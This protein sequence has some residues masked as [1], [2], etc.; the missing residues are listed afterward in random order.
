M[1]TICADVP[2]PIVKVGRLLARKTATQK[3]FAE[4]NTI[5]KTAAGTSFGNKNNCT[6]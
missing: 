5:Y 2:L 3:V 6:E 1:S 4:K